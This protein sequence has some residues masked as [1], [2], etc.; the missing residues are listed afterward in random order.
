DTAHPA[1]HGCI[2]WHSACHATWALLAHRR[3][4]GD[5]KYASIVDEILMPQKLAAEA[6]DLAA[7]PDFEMPY[8]RAWFLRLALED[9][10]ITGSTRCGPMGREMADS[11]VAKYR[12]SPPNPFAREYASP[13]WAL[14]NLLDYA[15]MENKPDFETFVREMA[16]AHFVPALDRQPSA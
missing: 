14:T 16:A 8:G 12:A 15:R 1:F 6:A 7:R 5:A 10:L 9:R 11:L 2:D 4:T 13:A 3:L